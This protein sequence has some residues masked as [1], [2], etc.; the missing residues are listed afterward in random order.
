MD[1]IDTTNIHVSHCILWP[2]PMH[3]HKRALAQLP[4]RILFAIT[5]NDDN[6]IMTS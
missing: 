2:H 5:H 4:C 1:V 3:E 6:T